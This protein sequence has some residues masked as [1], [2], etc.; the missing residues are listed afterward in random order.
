MVETKRFK[1]IP[2]PGPA[3]TTPPRQ[4]DGMSS[5][6][7]EAIFFSEGRSETALRKKSA[8]NEHDR[9]EKFRDEFEKMAIWGLKIFGVVIAALIGSWIWHL[10]MPIHSHW[11]TGDQLAKIQTLATG[12]IVA[13]I[14]AGHV[15]KRLGS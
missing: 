3:E 7:E 9:T 8:E 5:G 10:V 13:S 14:A 2:D 15:K 6:Q 4:E 12:G 1:T 11:L